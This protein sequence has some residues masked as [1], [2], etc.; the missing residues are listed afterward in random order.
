MTEINRISVI[1]PCLNEEANLKELLPFLNEHGGDILSEIIVSDGGSEDNSLAIAESYGAILVRSLVRCRASQLNLGAQKAKGDILYFVH[2]DTRPVKSF[3]KIILRSL[4]EGK[5]VGCFR[6]RF[7]ADTIFLQAN[8]WFTRFNSLFSG[9]GDQSL[10]IEKSFFN[11]LN[12]FDESFTI[13][14]DFELVRRIRQKSDFHVLSYEMTVSARKY[15]DNNWLKVQLAN[16]TAFALFL[17]KVKPA[18][19]KSL[20]L[21]FL[22][23]KN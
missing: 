6:Y 4:A 7:D 10:F 12:G 8:S 11:K 13:M 19:I 2:A 21:N 3:A 22:S 20:Y 9:G 23:R 18:S 16:F 5:R 15:M 17:L 1:I 14:E